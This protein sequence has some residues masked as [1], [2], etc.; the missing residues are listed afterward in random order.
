[1][2]SAAAAQKHARKKYNTAAALRDKRCT[3]GVTAQQAAV[4]LSVT[5]A[6]S[7]MAI[8][9]AA[10]ACSV[11]SITA[12]GD[13]PQHHTRYIM[14]HCS[15]QPHLDLSA[16]AATHVLN[17]ASSPT[18]QLHRTLMISLCHRS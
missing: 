16:A 15:T 13:M 2:Q 18:A 12:E 8:A 14:L 7:T 4:R 10:E 9:S 17:D 11:L 1:M 5:L 6:A 3:R